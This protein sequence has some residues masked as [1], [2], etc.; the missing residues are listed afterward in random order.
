MKR[1]FVA[2]VVFL[3]CFTVLM[4]TGV[5]PALSWLL[6]PVSL[7]EAVVWAAIVSA[8]QTLVLFLA[9]EFAFWV[10]DKISA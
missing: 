1:L 10:I 8:W 7:P 2:A 3:S 5:L 6:L 4:L 9:I